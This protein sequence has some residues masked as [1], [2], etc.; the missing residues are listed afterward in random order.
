MLTLTLCI[1]SFVAGMLCYKFKDT[2][3]G[4]MQKK[5]PAQ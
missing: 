4:W 3:V 2:I 1:L 5:P